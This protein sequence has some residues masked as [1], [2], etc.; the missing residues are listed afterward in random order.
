MAVGGEPPGTPLVLE[1]ND[2]VIDIAEV[3]R[4]AGSALPRLHEDDLLD[5][6]LIVTELVSNVYDHGKF[7]ARLLLEVQPEGVRIVVEDASPIPPVLK[8]SS[9]HSARGRGL[10][11][12][13]QLAGEWGVTEQPP[14]KAVWAVV[15][16]TAGA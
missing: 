5:V 8:P 3:R 12:V 11:L 4:W 2:D 1:L 13:D 6:Q 9:P 15:P 14:G 16:C 10:V 7:P